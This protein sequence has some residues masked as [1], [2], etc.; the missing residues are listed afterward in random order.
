MSDKA[1]NNNTSWRYRLD[2]I[3]SLPGETMPAKKIVWEKLHE[4][5]KERPSSKKNYWYRAAAI[6]LLMISMPWILN[7]EKQ[8]INNQ[9][10]I[11]QTPVV[12][13]NSKNTRPDN[14]TFNKKETGIQVTEQNEIHSISTEIKNKPRQLMG[15][16]T[17]KTPDLMTVRITTSPVPVIHITNSLPDSIIAISNI[18]TPLKKLRVIHINELSAQD[19]VQQVADGNYKF[20]RFVGKDVSLETQ[21]VA[22]VNGEHILIR[23]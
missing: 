6:L 7:K 2:K 13:V 16:A 21:N 11:Q 10:A 1:L 23:N 18:P 3:E 8:K 4:R 19:N 15:I 14:L 17:G 20:R 12:S 5:L 22:P 9:S